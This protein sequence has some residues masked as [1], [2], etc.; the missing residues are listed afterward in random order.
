MFF[1]A[2]TPHV[3]YLAAV[4]CFWLSY[5]DIILT[6]SQSK[7]SWKYVLSLLFYFLSLIFSQTQFGKKEDS[8]NFVMEENFGHAVPENGIETPSKTHHGK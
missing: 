7:H 4:V 6:F 5:F 3:I 2:F 8:Q 1:F